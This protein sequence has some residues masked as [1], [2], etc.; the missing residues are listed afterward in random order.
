MA[1]DGAVRIREAVVRYRGPHRR[2]AGAI[3][4]PG[5]VARFVRGVV[6]GDAREHFVSI[7]LDA[8]HQPIAYQVVSIGTA[9]ASLVHPREVFQPAVGLG[10]CALIVAH[11]HPSGNVTP[12]A[13]DRDV[14]RRLAEAGRLLGIRLLDSVVVAGLGY[15]SLQEES[16]SLLEGTDRPQ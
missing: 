4:S 2:M 8:R 7:L 15:V 9:T 6:G 12:S 10:A 5:D 1:G 13:E 16:P 14:T 3:R 11:N